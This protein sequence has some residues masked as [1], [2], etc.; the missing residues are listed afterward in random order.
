MLLIELEVN[1]MNEE[2]RT[3]MCFKSYLRT[4]KRCGEIFRTNCKGSKV[5]ESCYKPKGGNNYD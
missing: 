5:C 2:L 3:K 1:K 4:C